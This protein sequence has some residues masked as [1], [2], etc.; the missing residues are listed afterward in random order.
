MA[1][2]SSKTTAKKKP[3]KTGSKRSA[4]VKKRSST[5][6]TPP[7]SRASLPSIW[8]LSKSAATVLWDHNRL[9][10]GITAVFLVLN[11]VLV[12]GLNDSNA[13]NSLDGHSFSP[14][15]DSFV[16]LIGTTGTSSSGTGD[17]YQLF[18]VLLASLA[19]VWALRQVIAGRQIRIRDAFYQ[20]MYPFVPLLL[21]LLVISLQFVP[22]LIGSGLYT[23]A[24]GNGIA[25]GTFQTI[26]WAILFIGLALVS[27]Y[28]L[29]SSL[30]ALYI[31]TL[32][33]MTPLKALRSAR[34][35][36]RH[37]RLVIIR[38]LLALPVIIFVL[39]AVIM[40]PVIIV[41]QPVAPWI[42]FVL[43]AAGLTL[44]HSY[45]YTV[46]RALLASEESA[47]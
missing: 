12:Q 30:F 15:L 25:I 47:S 32:P 31:V 21:V 37:R 46:Y 13:A 7:K 43:A 1:T 41:I 4:P 42:F 35:L 10:G 45:L 16:K 40:V 22:L 17:P 27:F 39:A 36:V 8:K 38:K 20:G 33:D 2:T 9:F 19:L 24:V 34:E 5:K 29:A 23:L 28:W 26:L 18:T 14:G 44:T 6:N 11:L 3:A